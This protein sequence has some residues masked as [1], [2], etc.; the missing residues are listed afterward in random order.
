MAKSISVSCVSPISFG[1][2]IINARLGC[3]DHT[4]AFLKSVFMIKKTKNF[5]PLVS[6]TR[7]ELYRK[8][9]NLRIL[10]CGGDGTVRPIPFH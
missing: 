9:P 6:S 7:L 3:L 2:L 4:A 1:L 8:M 5:S 10:A